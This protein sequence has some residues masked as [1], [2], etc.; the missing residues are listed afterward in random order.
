MPIVVNV[1]GNEQVAFPPTDGNPTDTV[2]DTVTFNNVVRTPGTTSDTPVALFPVDPQGNPVGTPTGNPGEYTLPNGTTVQ[3]LDNNG[4]P[5]TNFDGNGNPVVTV[6][7]NSEYN[8]KVKVSYPDPSDTDTPP[9]YTTI[10]GADLDPAPQGTPTTPQAE[11]NTT[12]VIVP[13]GMQFGDAT[14][15]Q[16][17]DPQ[18]VNVNT[19]K[20]GQKGTDITFP[21]DISNTS[22]TYVDDL[23]NQ[24]NDTYDVSGYVVIQTETGSRAVPVVYEGDGVQNSGR[25]RQVPVDINN[26]GVVDAN[27][28][29]PIYITRVVA[30]GTETKITARVT[31]PDN[32]LPTVDANGNPINGG[33]PCC[34]SKPSRTT[35]ISP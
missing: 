5:F 12:N 14:G 1:S 7:A 32:A 18:L 4:N 2:P 23:G 34:S 17:A 33:N 31:I 29:V 27:D 13:A 19:P 9:S 25:T 6:P 22:S 26:D 3:L 8:Y 16:G 20:D 21:M 24:Y 30:P 10:I 28:V 11:S 15:P 35:A